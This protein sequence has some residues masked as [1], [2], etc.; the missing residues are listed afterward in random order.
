MANF[1]DALD[2]QGAVLRKID[3]VK[4]KVPSIIYNFIKNYL[5]MQTFII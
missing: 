2:I 4:M 1:M 5:I 3:T